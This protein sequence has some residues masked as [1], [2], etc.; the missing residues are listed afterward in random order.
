MLRL[1]PRVYGVGGDFSQKLLVGH[2]VE[3]GA[4]YGVVRAVYHAEVLTDGDCRVELISRDH[5]RSDSGLA[6]L[7][8]S[9]LNLR[10]NRVYHAYESDEYE[11]LLKIGIGVVARL[12]IINSHGK[13]QH[14]QSFSC[15]TSVV[16][17]NISGELIRD[18]NHAVVSQY[19]RAVAEH[20]VR[21]TLC[22][23][24]VRGGGNH[25]I[26][27]CIEARRCVLFDILMNRRHHLT[28]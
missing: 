28:A 10:T 20:Y 26:E 15:H 13:R 12:F 27:L 1:H 19:A 25:L 18:R 22:E 17:L 14:S 23:L 9:G 6:A 2:V 4:E 24:H 16:S 5:D 7:G 21:R 3:G 8:H 11:V